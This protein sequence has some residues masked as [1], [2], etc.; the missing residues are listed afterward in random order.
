MKKVKYND[1]Y[2]YIDDSEL[3]ESMTGISLERYEELKKEKENKAKEN[4]LNNKL[5]HLNGEVDE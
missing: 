4:T 1:T 5:V 3:D 2:I